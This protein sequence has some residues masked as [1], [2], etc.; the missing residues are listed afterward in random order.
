MTIF[1]QNVAKI[2][3]QE[4]LTTT[5]LARYIGVSQK[6]VQRILS[7]RAVSNANYT[8]AYRT[9]RRVAD[10]IGLSTDDVFKYHIHFEE[11]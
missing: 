8:P 3:R 7:N 6:T 5:E 1:A 9:V 11:V 10:K 2:Q 4:G